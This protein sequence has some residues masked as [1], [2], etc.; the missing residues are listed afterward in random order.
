M[1]RMN[2]NEN[3]EEKETAKDDRGPR[4]SF[5]NLQ[6]IVE[7]LTIDGFRASRSTIYRHHA[8]KKIKCEKNGA[9]SLGAVLKYANRFLKRVDGASIQS[10]KTEDLQ[11]RR[12]KA[13]IEKLESQARAATIRADVLT[14][15]YVER[16]LFEN[17]LAKRA[18]FLKNDLSSFWHARAGAIIALVNGDSSK[19]PDLIFFGS[20]AV[21][22]WISRYA[23]D[24]KFP[25]EAPAPMINLND[26]M[27]DDDETETLDD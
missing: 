7:F 16:G 19:I 18:L 23:R 17:E 15:A 11:D 24:E 9:Y 8:E 21:D 5:S 6:Q 13:E 25:I 1:G 14:G 10:K 20:E 2:E 4:A 26:E 12:L 3:V 22:E 27:D